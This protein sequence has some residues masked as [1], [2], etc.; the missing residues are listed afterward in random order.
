MKQNTAER[1]CTSYAE[2]QQAIKSLSASISKLWWECP[3]LADQNKYDAK[4]HLQVL[5][6]AQKE[7]GDECVDEESA[8]SECPQCNETLEKIKRRKEIRLELGHIKVAICRHG[9]AL[10][11]HAQEQS[12]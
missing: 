8:V 1:L 6:D 10:A 2:K 9:A 4:S 3:L 12:R 11:K 7:H 5:F